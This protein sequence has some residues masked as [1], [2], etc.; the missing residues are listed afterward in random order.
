[1]F[2]LTH[3]H[4][5]ANMLCFHLCKTKR[6]IFKTMVTIFHAVTM[7]G[8]WSIKIQKGQKK[9][10]KKKEI[11][12]RNLFYFFCTTVF[13]KLCCLKIVLTFLLFL[14][15]FPPI[16]IAIMQ[17][18]R[19]KHTRAENWQRSPKQEERWLY[20]CI[21]DFLIFLSLP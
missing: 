6:G 8:N 2:I 13:P 21:E 7:S 20:G 15:T 1:M 16:L 4:V 5:V 12:Y 3:L 19:W 18:N 11:Y 9:K 14:W 17:I 10:K